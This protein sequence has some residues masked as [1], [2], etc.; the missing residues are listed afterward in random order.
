MHRRA[1]MKARPAVERLEAKQ[2]PS[3]ALP[4]HALHHKADASALHAADRA[5]DVADGGE[6]RE[7]RSAALAA[8]DP[9]QPPKLARAFFGFRLTNPS[10][11]IRLVKPIP[12][13][14]Q[15]LVQARQPRPGQVYNV[16]SVAVRNGSAQTFTAANGFTVKFPNRSPSKPVPILT[17]SQVWHPN[18]WYVFYVLTKKYYPLKSQISGGF[19]FDLGGRST[20]LVP[21]PSAIFLRL[22]YNPATFARTLD[23]I[24][25]Y[26][27]GAQLGNGPPFGMP[28]TQINQIVSANARK[29]DFGGRF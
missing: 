29:I 9:G 15:V 7:N 25:A 6:A 11:P 26:G 27:Q 12:P 1:M 22:K 17:G 18:H 21:G 2:L 24:I 20:T 3:A 23:W 16:L 10:F 8:A 5:S 4:A 13:F 19:Q 14:G 28:D